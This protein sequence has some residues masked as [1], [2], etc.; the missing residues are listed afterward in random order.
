MNKKG[1]D[2][3]VK[4]TL[5]RNYEQKVR[6]TSPNPV[7]YDVACTSK[8]TEKSRQFSQKDK[9]L[10]QPTLCSSEALASYLS[11]VKKSLPP[12]AVEDLNIEKG[13]L[14]SKVT[15]K[16]N[17][18]INDRIYRNLIALNANVDELKTTKN[19]RP[20]SGMKQ[21]KRD[22]EPKIEDFYQ[23]EEETDIA[24]NVPTIKPKFK[25][26]KKSYDGDLHQLVASF[27]I[28]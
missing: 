16:L 7:I 24:P 12:P 9:E 17:F 19:R 20:T 28:L 25:P 3:K 2:P 14:T 22:L 18:H 4:K 1:A 21:L 13:E 15:K 10:S 8:Q 5:I 11:D 26:V 27:E 6:K 23:D